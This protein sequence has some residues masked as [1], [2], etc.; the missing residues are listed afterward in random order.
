MMQFMFVHMP[1][2]TCQI[3]RTTLW[4]LFS[5]SIFT[6]VPGIETG[7]LGA[8]QTLFTYCTISPIPRE[9]IKHK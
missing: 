4:V 7:S 1:Q 8:Q 9:K 5:S 6:C 3:Q 2:H